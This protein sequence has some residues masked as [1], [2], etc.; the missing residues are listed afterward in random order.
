MVV[1]PICVQ[2]ALKMLTGLIVKD[3]CM[4]YIKKLKKK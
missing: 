3:T 4:T 2:L 1:I